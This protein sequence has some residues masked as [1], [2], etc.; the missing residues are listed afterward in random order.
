MPWFGLAQL[1]EALSVGRCPPVLP[2]TATLTVVV[3][4]SS[5]P[6]GSTTAKRPVEISLAFCSS[7]TM[8]PSDVYVALGPAFVADIAVPPEAG[9]MV[10]LANAGVAPNAP[11]PAAPTA[12]A[13]RIRARRVLNFNRIPFR[14]RQCGERRRRR[15]AWCRRYGVDV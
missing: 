3:V 7:T 4:R 2:D 8:L 12:D 14:I 1:A 13:A 5:K 11:T 9:V 10:V 6:D 15:R